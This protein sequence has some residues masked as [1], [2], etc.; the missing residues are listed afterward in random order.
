MHTLKRKTT[1]EKTYV[2]QKE[3]LGINKASH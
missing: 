3:T 2:I 1:R